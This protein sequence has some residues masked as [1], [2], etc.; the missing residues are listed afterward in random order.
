MSRISSNTGGRTQL[1]LFFFKVMIGKSIPEYVFI[2]A[3]I[4][5]LRLIAPLSIVWVAL[6]L[7]VPAP[8]HLDPK[9]TLLHSCSLMYASLEVVFFVCAYLPRRYHLQKVRILI[10]CRG[11]WCSLNMLLFRLLGGGSPETVTQGTP[12]ALSEIF[13]IPQVL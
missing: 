9:W 7:L 13:R 10:L 3:A 2:K 6:V 12:S 1:K 8:A 5:A 11:R 4:T